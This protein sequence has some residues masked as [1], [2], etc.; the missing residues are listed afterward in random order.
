MR[1]AQNLAFVQMRLDSGCVKLR[2]G[3]VGRQDL[4]P[5][6]AL[7]R[8]RG[9]ENDHAIGARLLGRLALRVETDDDVRSAI[10]QVLR[11]RMSLRAVAENGDGL[12]LKG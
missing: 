9:S 12:S 3:L 7:R 10:A 5:V 11:L 6:R 2:L 8:L 4:D 1:E